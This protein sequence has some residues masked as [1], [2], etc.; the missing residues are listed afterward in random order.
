MTNDY[1]L[2]HE[3]VYDTLYNSLTSYLIT[4]LDENRACT[5]MLGVGDVIPRHTCMYVKFARPVPVNEF[6][7][8]NM[9]ILNTLCCSYRSLITRN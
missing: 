8:E 5:L 1:I 7:V 4:N 2:I 6:D 3:M 9:N